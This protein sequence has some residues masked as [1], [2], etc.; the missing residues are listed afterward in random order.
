MLI[1]KNNLRP[2]LTLR[3]QWWGNSSPYS[4]YGRSVCLSSMVMACI[5]YVIPINKVCP[6][7][8]LTVMQIPLCYMLSDVVS[9]EK[10]Q[11]SSTSRVGPSWHIHKFGYLKIKSI[12]NVAKVNHSCPNYAGFWTSNK[13]HEDPHKIMVKIHT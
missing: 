5:L 12:A 3:I 2:E 11:K 1:F 13:D 7:W 9:E 10:S 6:Y 8:T 4:V